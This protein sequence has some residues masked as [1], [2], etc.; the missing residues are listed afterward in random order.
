[1]G[2]AVLL[3]VAVVINNRMPTRYYPANEY[4]YRFW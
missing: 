1:M 2:I 4:W 3:L